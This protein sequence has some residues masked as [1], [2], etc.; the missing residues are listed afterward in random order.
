MRIFL[1]SSICIVFFIS[2]KQQETNS[3]KGIAMTI[4]YEVIVDTKIGRDSSEEIQRILSETFDEID[5]TYNKWNPNSEVS[6]INALPRNQVMQLS[7]QLSKF[8]KHCARFVLIDP[9][10]D[11]TVEPLQGLLV[12]EHLRNS[13]PSDEKIASVKGAV[14]WSNLVF[15]EDRVYKKN[16]STAL[17]LSSLAK[18]YCVDLL[19]E[20]LKNIGCN[21]LYVEWGGEIRVLGK[22]PQGR[23]WHIGVTTAK[24]MQTLA[25]QDCAIATSGDYLQT[26]KVQERTYTHIVDIRLLTLKE[27]KES[28]I[29]TATVIAH[30]CM[31]ADALATMLLLCDDID[32][33]KKLIERLEVHFPESSFLVTSRND[34]IYSTL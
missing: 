22:H 7:P 32:D 24:G 10:F 6:R 1:Y 23:S 21:T 29:A 26:W 5:R 25:L 20:R 11:P 3:Y 12:A 19:S 14:G 17:D 2:C 15:H 16:S 28:S 31:T 30:D 33:A 27:I 34:R 9:R 13:F 4:P 8:L 18:G